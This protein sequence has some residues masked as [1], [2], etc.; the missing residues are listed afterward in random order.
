MRVRADGFLGGPV[1]RIREESTE[2][3][4]IQ[5]CSALREICIDERETD[6]GEGSESPLE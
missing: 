2:F 6:D 3:M 1:N 5:L 4:P